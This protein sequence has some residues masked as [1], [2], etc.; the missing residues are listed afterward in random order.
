MSIENTLARIEANIATL[1]LSI[2]FAKAAAEIS[3]RSATV[4]VSELLGISPH[5]AAKRLASAPANLGHDGSV[6]DDVAPVVQASFLPS[7]PPA[8]KERK[9]RAKKT[10]KPGLADRSHE[11][12]CDPWIGWQ[13]ERL[14][15][16]LEGG[17][18]SVWKI[19]QVLGR[20]TD[21]ITWKVGELGH[22]V[23]CG[24]VEYGVPPRRKVRKTERSFCR[25]SAKEDRQIRGEVENGLTTEQIAARHQRDHDS[26]WRRCMKLGLFNVRHG[27]EVQK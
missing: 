3:A 8:Q 13:I 15:A 17:E 20:S 10:G 24:H 12:A 16:L 1:A 27:V 6:S 21:S 22:R 26:I 11:H 4:L 2:E 14:Q 25:Y 18:T 7:P 19:S 5:E 23:S 9:H